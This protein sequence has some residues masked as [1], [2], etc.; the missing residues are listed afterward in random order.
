[1][2]LNTTDTDNSQVL[3]LDG[4]I[5]R[6]WQPKHP[7]SRRITLLVHGHTGDENSMTVFTRNL[8]SNTW[9]FS[10]RGPYPTS[11]G[12]YKWIAA[13][14]GLTASFKEF[15][16]AAQ[17]LD[18]ALSSWK[19]TFH[20]TDQKIDIAGFSQGSVI[21]LT[22]A[23]TF[24]AKVRRAAGISGFLPQDTPQWIQGKP[25]AGLPVFIAHGTED[26]TVPF[27]RAQEIE[28]WL[29]E[30]G[31]ALTFCEAAVGHRISANCFRSF[32][33]FFANHEI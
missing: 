31:A 28:T 22:Y 16:A 5:V 4:W 7:D 13:E 8:P 27:V 11:E 15:Q 30:Y 17:M 9:V 33:N 14:N 26:Q 25:L 1:M 3:D 19:N 2:L 18:E 32:A 23:L 20:L 29:T 12:G 24:P 6:V 10:P 21:A